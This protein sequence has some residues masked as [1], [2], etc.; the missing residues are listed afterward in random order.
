MF[1]RPWRAGNV[2]LAKTRCRDRSSLA[3]AADGE[4]EVIVA[5]GGDGTISTVA[6][7]VA[8]A[9]KT[10]GV[11][12]LGT[13]NN[14]SKDLGIPQDFAGAVK[15][16]ATG[17]VKI[18][19]SRRGQ[20][21]DHSSTIRAS[22]C[23]RGSFC[24]ARSSSGSAAG[25]GMRRFGRRCRCFAC[26][27]FLKVRIEIDGK[28]FLA[29]DAVRFC[30]QQRVRNGSLQYRP[31]RRAGRRRVERVLSASRR[32][33]GRDA[34]AFSHTFGGLRQWKDFEEVSTEEVTIQTRKKK[35]HVAF[36]GEVQTMQTPLAL[37]D[38]A[39]GV[40]GDRP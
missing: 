26:R 16:I 6:A 28:E 14:F 32:A 27:R 24:D 29:K 1:H 30:R 2:H 38:H 21:P 22:G 9:G 40:E 13:L 5:G 11:L 17:N 23:I 4:A 34:F 39:E 31:P 33:L 7:E 3:E 15:T 25:N 36:D 35:L 37:S 19:R 10:L 20:R 8:K 12:P 18:D